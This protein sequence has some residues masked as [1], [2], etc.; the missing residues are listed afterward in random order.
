M[1]DIF[2][3]SRPDNQSWWKEEIFC[4]GVF[5]SWWSTDPVNDPWI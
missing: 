2:D 4:W 3:E 1:L 5:C